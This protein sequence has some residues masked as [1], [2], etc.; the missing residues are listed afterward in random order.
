MTVLMHPLCHYTDTDQEDVPEIHRAVAEKDMPTVAHLVMSVDLNAT[1]DFQG[2]LPLH[3]AVCCSDSL[4][5]EAL[6]NAGADPNALSQGSN[7]LLP[8]SPLCL[9]IQR[10]QL[11]AIDILLKKGANPTEAMGTWYLLHFVAWD[12]NFKV[13]K[14]MLPYVN[15]F[16]ISTNCPQT[17][18]TCQ[19]Y[20]EVKLHETFLW[21]LVHDGLKNSHFN[22]L[23]YTIDCIGIHPDLLKTEMKAGGDL[24]LLHSVMRF[25]ALQTKTNVFTTSDQDI[26]SKIIKFLLIRG[27]KLNHELFSALRVEIPGSR[28]VPFSRKINKELMKRTRNAIQHMES[29][30]GYRMTHSQACKLLHFM[31]DQEPFQERRQELFQYSQEAQ[32]G[33]RLSEYTLEEQSFI[34]AKVRRKYRHTLFSILSGQNIPIQDPQHDVGLES[35]DVS[36]KP[37]TIHKLP[38]ELRAIIWGK[39]VDLKNTPPEFLLRREQRQQFT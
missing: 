19:G 27:A 13:L 22:D 36:S 28:I 20:E 4:I 6:L 12:Q 33:R 8:F 10:K 31:P 7:T 29:L 1:Y 30:Y 17:V 32:Q 9:A 21:Y 23:M 38:V 16:H 25:Q 35:T 15:D 3:V 39:C 26:C 24:S 18:I 37:L 34:T 14:R 11:I 5:I 2:A